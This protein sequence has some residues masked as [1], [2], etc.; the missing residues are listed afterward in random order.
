MRIFFVI[1]S[2]DLGGAESQLVML[3]QELQR[4]GVFC[5]VF[6]LNANGVLRSKLNDSGIPVHNGRINFASRKLVKIFQFIRAFYILWVTTR[7]ATTLHAYLPLTNF[8]GALIGCLRRTDM[9]ITSRRALGTHQNRWPWWKLFDKIS[10]ALSNVVV[11]NSQAVADDTVLRDG[12]PRKKVVVIHNG[13]D[14][15]RF[16]VAANQRDV[17]RHSLGI[18]S[19]VKVIIIVANLIPYK[20]HADL[21]R[22]LAEL[23]PSYSDVHLLIVGQDRGISPMLHSLAQELGLSARIQWLGIRHDIPELLAAADIYVCASHEEGFSNSLMEALAAGKAVVATRVGGNPELLEYGELG[24]LVEPKDPRGLASA[25]TNLLAD[26]AISQ[27]YGKKGEFAIAQ[28]YGPTHM[29][30]QYISLYK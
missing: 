23:D 4:Q 8:Y 19:K 28:R 24:L 14:S 26:N 22:A 27:N 12:I 20:G 13:L 9:V 30:R 7:G 10:N 6:A 21:L 5:E 16:R 15:S 1:G 29:A 25:L 3:T 11:A 18:N 2:L 17:V